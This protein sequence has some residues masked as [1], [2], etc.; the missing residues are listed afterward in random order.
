MHLF[1]F[2]VLESWL[3]EIKRFQVL[4]SGCR[5]GHNFP[6][7]FVEALIGTTPQQVGLHCVGHV[8]L[9]VAHLMVCSQEVIHGHL[10]AHLDPAH[11]SKVSVVRETVAQREAA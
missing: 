11:Q 1:T 2:I 3:Q 6:Y 9:D 5:K 4:R 8:V 7:S 10:G